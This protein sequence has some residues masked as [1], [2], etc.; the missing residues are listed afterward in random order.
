MNIKQ[1]SPA[2]KIKSSDTNANNA[3]LKSAIL[4]GWVSI[5]DIATYVG[6]DSPSFQ[7]SLPGDYS[8]IISAGMR[9]AYQQLVSLSNYFT[10]NSNNSDSVG[11]ASVSNIGTPTF[12]SGKFGNALTLNGTDQ[13][14]SITDATG[15]HPTVFSIGKYI[16]TSATGVIQTIFQ[17]YSTTGG[18]A[19]GISFVISATNKLYFQLGDNTS[20]TPRSI[21]GNT[22]VTDGSEHYVV[23]TLTAEGWAQIYL[24]GELEASGYL[25]TPV[26]NATN[27]VRIGV[28][29]YT[30]TSV[31][32]TW[33]SGQ[34]DDLFL[35]NGYALSET[36]IAAKYALGTAQGTGAITEQCYALFTQVSY[37]SP[38]TTFTIYTGTDYA[39]QSAT[40]SN[41][42]F[43]PVKA[44]YGFPLKEHKWTYTYMSSDATSSV[45]PAAA[46]WYNLGSLSSSVPIGNWKLS[47]SIPIFA[48]IGS[49]SID[50][51]AGISLLNSG[52]PTY[53][54]SIDYRGRNNTTAY[55]EILGGT[56]P[57]SVSYSAKTTVYLMESM[58]QDGTNLALSANNGVVGSF[59]K[60]TSTFL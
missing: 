5:D 12:T 13:A 7:F 1:F 18:N 16:K 29:C 15:F 42:M 6:A 46:T 37:S 33:F 20:S 27:Y 32:S 41:P 30:G 8:G 50:V 45:D 58:L 2:T 28:S 55:R 3:L 14:L 47:Y 26:Y 19:Q 4:S 22:T 43:S 53:S 52:P 51:L 10:F 35:I 23:F 34:I 56:Y 11:S 57:I 24:D 25:G 60:A 49:G 39:L 44:P 21:N 38:D 36:T 17:S 9:F 59:L 40:I 54:E 31:A 48:Q